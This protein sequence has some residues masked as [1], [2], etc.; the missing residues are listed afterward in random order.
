LV[1]WEPYPICMIHRI[2]KLSPNP[3]TACATHASATHVTT[4]RRDSQSSALRRASALGRREEENRAR[5]RQRMRKRESGRGNYEGQAD[6]IISACYCTG[7]HGH[8][9][10]PGWC[11]GPL[12]PRSRNSQKPHYSTSECHCPPVDTVL[13][14]SRQSQRSGTPKSQFSRGLRVAKHAIGVKL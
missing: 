14:G 4:P 1:F 7:E 10:K 5:Q 6:E 8:N 11:R 2:P 13:V 9:P 12:F 3:A